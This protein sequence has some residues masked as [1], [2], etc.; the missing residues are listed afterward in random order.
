[1]RAAVGT[2]HRYLQSRANLFPVVYIFRTIMTVLNGISS[3]VST[4]SSCIIFGDG[5]IFDI[6]FLDG[7]S[8]IVLWAVKG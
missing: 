4:E 8:L 5:K 3:P 2:A 1:M 7:D 6:K